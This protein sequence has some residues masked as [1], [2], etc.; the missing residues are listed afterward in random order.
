M[1]QL[2]T[3]RVLL[4]LLLCCVLC[5]LAIVGGR[6]GARLTHSHERW[7][8]VNHQPVQQQV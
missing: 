8:K 4:L 1:Y 5:S 2:V 3:A 6:G 7:V